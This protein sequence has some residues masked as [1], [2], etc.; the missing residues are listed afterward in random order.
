[1]R[2]SYTTNNQ[3]RHICGQEGKCISNFGN[4]KSYCDLCGLEVDDPELSSRMFSIIMPTFNRPHLIN[5]AISSVLAQDY[6]NWE[7]IIM[8]GGDKLSIPFE[9]ER[10]KLFEESD[11]GITDAMNKGMKLAYGNILCWCNDDDEMNP[12]TL[13]W[14]DE[15]LTEDWGY[16]LIT[17]TDGS[18]SYTWGNLSGTLQDLVRNNFV[19][20]PA[21]FWTR[22][23]YEAVG[24]MDEAQ[25]LTS[26][27]EYWMRLW[28][29]KQP[30]WLNRFMATYHLHPEQ[31]TQKRQAEQIRQA[32]ESAKKYDK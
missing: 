19:P 3:K 30:Q 5:R 20:Q 4:K 12:G 31:I 17:M 29:Y 25:D 6:D 22:E 21:V 23:A 9:D 26:D 7:L 27:Y 1:M 14:V 15:N 28:K 13:K 18:K 8:N 10:I 11:K 16:G 32:R 24:P 2:K